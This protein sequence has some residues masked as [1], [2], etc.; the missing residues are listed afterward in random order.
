MARPHRSTLERREALLRLVTSGI[1]RVEELGSRLEVSPSTVRRDLAALEDSGQLSRT[2]GG[3]IMPAPFRDR[4]LSERVAVNAESKTGIGL[5]S[6]GLVHA[7]AT[8]FVD[9]GSTTLALV[10]ALDG[11][12]GV[13]V[14]TRGLENAI[15]L[16]GRPGISVHVVGGA[17]TP[18]SHGTTGPLALEALGRFAFDLAFLGCDAVSPALGVGEP[19]LEEAYVKEFAATRARRTVVL[20]DASKLCTRGV[21]AWAPLPHGWTLVTDCREETLL[22][23]FERQGV[24]VIR[25]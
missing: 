11:V 17:L 22:A 15:T 24:D 21:A 8:I 9:A 16:V 4:A 5:A 14:V 6:V 2:Y 25:A 13:T 10:D 18:A 20:A 19:T 12:E 23:P 7:G 3:A 1:S